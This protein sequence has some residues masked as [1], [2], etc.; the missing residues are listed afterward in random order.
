M[1]GTNESSLSGNSPV[2]EL[3]NYCPYL[4]CG[5]LTVVGAESRCCGQCGSAF[6]VCLKC[7]ATNRL[8][9]EFCRGCGQTLGTEAWPME[10]GLRSSSIQRDSIRSLNEVHAPFP[11]RLGVGV[12]ATPIAADG[13]L[14]IAL[15]NGGVALLSE[16]TG[17]R[18]GDL[19]V[20]APIAV[21][22][23][24]Q[25]GTLFAASGNRLYA[26]DLAEFLDQPSL[27][28][29]APV[30]SFACAENAVTQPLL[31]DEKAVYLLTSRNQHAVLYAVAQ[32]NGVPLWPEPLLL[33]TDQMAPPLL[34]EGQI[35]LISGSGQVS[36]VETGT[37]EITGSFSLNRRVDLQVKP[38]VVDNRVFFSDPGGYVCELVMAPGGPLINPLY[39][40]RLRISSIAASSQFIAL[41][42]LSGLTLLSSRG[43]LLWT[44]N[45]NESVSTTPIISG[46]S[47]FA[48]DDSGSA[49]L[50]DVLKANPVRRMK[51]LPGEVGMSPLMT[52]SRIV[53]VAADGKVVALDWH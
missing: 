49:L 52:Q 1:T 27:Q 5:E 46:D 14:V 31:V 6:N 39:D 25:S 10:P 8:L 40:Q 28:Q 51:L 19:S 33:E 3:W 13:L 20:S 45:T 42:H 24:L 35:V 43:H 15:S 48:L 4:P 41:G 38:F 29:L 21:T 44:S 26:F 2:F 34:V 7:R 11:V 47:V 12:Q 17:E 50:F 37:G 32:N 53:V 18:I 16:H 30:W 23:A 36:V 9:A 22:P